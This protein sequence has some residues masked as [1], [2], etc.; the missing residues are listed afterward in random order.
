MARPSLLSRFFRSDAASPPPQP[1]ADPAPRPRRVL[2]PGQLRRERRALLRARE[3]RI[4]DLG[5]LMLEMFKR[6]RF[7]H[8]LVSE[9]CSELVAIDER[10]DELD[11]LLA[12]AAAAR[13]APR[14]QNRCA[15]G[16]PLIWGSHFCANCGRPVG[17]MAVVACEHCGNPLP[18]DVRFCA[19]CG[20]PVEDGSDGDGAGPE[21]SADVPLEAD[22]AEPAPPREPEAKA[23]EQERPSA[24]SPDR[25][26]G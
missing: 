26:E 8:E 12:A 2:T 19:A 17:E 23:G 13:R 14:S 1:S 7:S 4:R 18:A 16:A 11:S 3:E 6:D 20:A 24:P 9:Q 21:A 5:G 22:E 25:W 10:L 15:C